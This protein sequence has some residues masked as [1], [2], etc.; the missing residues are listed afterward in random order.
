MRHFFLITILSLGWTQP[1][2]KSIFLPSAPGSRPKCIPMDQT[3]C[4]DIGD[5]PVSVIMKLLK[6]NNFNLNSTFMD[7]SQGLQEPPERLFKSSSRSS[8][9]TRSVCQKSSPCPVHK[10]VLLAKAAVREDGEWR[11]VIETPLTIELCSEHT[12]SD[13]V[14][15]TQKYSSVKLNSLQSNG[16]I[17]EDWFIIP[18]CCSCNAK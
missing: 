18:S 10:K 15:R 12:N 13:S 4:E 16:R 2:Q 6:G 17:K 8:R 1:V 7:E 9:M 14:N 5:Y 11:Y 3:Y